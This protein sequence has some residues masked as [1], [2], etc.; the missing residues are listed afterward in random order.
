MVKCEKSMKERVLPVHGSSV[1]YQQSKLATIKEWKV[2]NSIDANNVFEYFR[3]HN[4]DV[5]SHCC[6]PRCQW[7]VGMEGMAQIVRFSGTVNNLHSVSD[8]MYLKVLA[9]QCHKILWQIVL[10]H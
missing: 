7:R 9:A 10:R 6:L 8:N 1:R 4:D 5:A 2:W 3:S